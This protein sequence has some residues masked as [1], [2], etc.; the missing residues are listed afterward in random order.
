VVK[1][2]IQLHGGRLEIRSGLGIGTRV[3]VRL[4]R[5]CAP[6]APK[7]ATGG[8]A[9]ARVVSPEFEKVKRSA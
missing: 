2:L 1:G 9:A 6:T 7:P 4:P 8:D 3:L 5:A